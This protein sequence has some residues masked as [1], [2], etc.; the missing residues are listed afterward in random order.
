MERLL[1]RAV[2]DVAVPCIAIPRLDDEE[3]GKRGSR[4]EL[5]PLP[6][7]VVA[8]SDEYEAGP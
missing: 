3:E 2:D 1:E 7:R 8:A 4:G 6:V 5:D